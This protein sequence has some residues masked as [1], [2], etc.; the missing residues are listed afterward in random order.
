MNP[1]FREG[2]PPETDSNLEDYTNDQNIH[3][4]SRMR[5]TRRQFCGALALTTGSGIWAACT[6]ASRS[7]TVVPSLISPTEVK[8]T[9][10]PTLVQ[11]ITETV[12]PKPIYE[13]VNVP[14]YNPEDPVRLEL[15]T[16]LIHANPNSVCTEKCAAYS[17][18]G[19]GFILSNTPNLRQVFFPSLTAEGIAPLGQWLDMPGAF[20]LKM[21]KINDPVKKAEFGGVNPFALI[22]DN[23]VV[24]IER[25]S[26]TLFPEF[27]VIEPKLCGINMTGSD[28]KAVLQFD[29]KT[30]QAVIKLF[31]LT[32]DG[33]IDTTAAPT[34]VKGTNGSYI[35]DDKTQQF[36]FEIPKVTAT[37]ML[38]HDYPREVPLPVL[39]DAVLEGRRSMV[40]ELLKIPGL[41]DEVKN[42]QNLINKVFA[43][44]NIATERIQLHSFSDGARWG[45]FAT[46]DGQIY[47]FQHLEKDSSGK[48]GWQNIRDISPRQYVNE[49]V[50]KLRA[51]PLTYPDRMN[52]AKYEVFA[53]NDW[54]LVGAY[55]ESNSLLGWFDAEHDKWMFE[56]EAQKVLHNPRGE[57]LG[58]PSI[59]VYEVYPV[60]YNQPDI[61]VSEIAADKI[62]PEEWR[63]K[64]SLKL[65]DGTLLP[66][67][68]F[69]A[70]PDDPLPT[71]VPA[72]LRWIRPDEA[73]TMEAAKFYP[74]MKL[75][76]IGFDVPVVNG[77][78]KMI[79]QI[80]NGGTGT[81]PSFLYQWL[82]DG[83]PIGAYNNCDS[84]KFKPTEWK[85]NGFP[86]YADIFPLLT[87]YIDKSILINVPKGNAA[88]TM[89]TQSFLNSLLNY[90]P[91][92]IGPQNP[93]RNLSVRTFYV[94]ASS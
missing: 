39:S 35:Y 11:I 54:L 42:V 83:F 37:P 66:P 56:K 16:Q 6:A 8:P 92:L 10:V 64:Y 20:D 72:I 84:T 26:S 4:A 78:L 19:S 41:Q 22:K 89:A 93:V 30:K 52:L 21:V 46:V 88:N 55:S 3:V 17:D 24:A 68:P 51:I 62:S 5:L 12:I 79:I 48:D 23:A 58:G 61:F 25:P 67:W 33:K 44:Q 81:W 87:R 31:P 60:N 50:T 32:A 13:I 75:T 15:S 76:D 90:Q 53:Y 59:V 36:V 40:N 18:G 45:V 47:I 73:A 71:I 29:A 9:N 49:D 7:S 70:K 65:S 43:K 69:K 1:D 74:D 80:A 28:K 91:I 82:T 57:V 14:I 63:N 85:Q 2:Q 77:T 34:D 27:L 86:R 38:T 94:P